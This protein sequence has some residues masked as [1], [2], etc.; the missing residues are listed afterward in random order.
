MFGIISSFQRKY[1]I[2]NKIEESENLAVYI[3][4]DLLTRQKYIFNQIKNTSKFVNSYLLNSDLVNIEEYSDRES[5][6][7]FSK[8][9]NLVICFPFE[10]GTKL[11]TKLDEKLNI[12]ESLAL[13]ESILLES[14][15]QIDGVFLN[16][17][18]VF[19]SES[20][21]L[22]NENN[23]YFNLILREEILELDDSTINLKD[24]AHIEFASDII[25]EFYQKSQSEYKSEFSILYKKAKNKIFN[26]IEEIIFEIR[27]LRDSIKN[28]KDSKSGSQ[29]KSLGKIK[30]GLFFL[31][32]LSFI[33]LIV[34]FLH[35]K[36]SENKVIDN[37]IKRFASYDIYGKKA[38]LN[39]KKL[40]FDY[41]VKLPARKEINVPDISRKKKKEKKKQDF[42]LYIVKKGD[43][44]TKISEKFFGDANHIDKIKT[45][46]NISDKNII[47]T[48][49]ILKIKLP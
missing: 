19:S 7:F 9:G 42:K 49:Q 14:I 20:I 32:K 12:E 46:N 45:D 25:Y 47:H 33:I 16:S 2:Q 36:F 8:D 29:I 5:G 48:N 39:I 35:A 41:S 28:T 37:E 23:V 26:S 43:T 1:E 18:I 17:V 24:K 22:S 44:L 10:N 15:D 21:V 30:K 27:E 3:A 6:F 11:K 13:L 31:M 38:V 4:E 34:Y 40:S